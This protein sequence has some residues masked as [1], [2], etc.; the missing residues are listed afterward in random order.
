MSKHAII[1]ANGNVVNT[2]ELDPVA[3]TSSPPEWSPP[4]GFKVEQSD[5][6]AIGWTYVNGVFTAPPAP[7][8][9]PIP[10]K[11]Q[12]LI[13]LNYVTGASGQ[14]MR[15]MAAGVAV[16]PTWSAYVLALR[17]ISNG[18]DTTSTALPTPPAFVLGT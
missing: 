11:Q 12:A 2:I 10:L 18:T 14:I 16:P 13:A 5:V 8:V 17:N 6:A 3:L 9:V 1:D 7:P 15:C 4:E